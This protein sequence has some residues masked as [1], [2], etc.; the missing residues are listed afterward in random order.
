MLKTVMLFNL[1]WKLGYLIVIMNIIY[2]KSKSFAS[3]W[4]SV[5]SLLISLI[6][7]SYWLQILNGSVYNKNEMIM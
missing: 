6:F 1:F 4:M 2:S 3:L 5:L 7:L